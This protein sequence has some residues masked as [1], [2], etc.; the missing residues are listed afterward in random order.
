MPPEMPFPRCEWEVRVHLGT[1]VE[2]FPAKCSTL[3]HVDAHPPLAVCTFAGLCFGCSSTSSPGRRVTYSIEGYMAYFRFRVIFLVLKTKQDTL[4]CSPWS[5]GGGGSWW[6]MARSQGRGAGPAG[7]WQNSAFCSSVN[8][9]SRLYSSWQHVSLVAFCTGSCPSLH[10]WV[11]WLPW[12]GHGV[13]AAETVSA[14]CPDLEGFADRKAADAW[15]AA[16]LGGKAPGAVSQGPPAWLRV[17]VQEG[18]LGAEEAGAGRSG[19][20]LSG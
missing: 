3:C 10:S 12:A 13:D 14:T 5:L 16:G 7:R 1:T 18:L 8:F 11:E 15:A 6:R 20:G 19:G 2:I 9:S 4:P 17:G